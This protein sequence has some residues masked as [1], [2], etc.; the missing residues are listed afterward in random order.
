MNS[1]V[2]HASSS[3]DPLREFTNEKFAKVMAGFTPDNKFERMLVQG[4]LFRYLPK[5][6]YSLGQGTHVAYDFDSSYVAGLN[7]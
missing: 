4:V 2:E 3:D 5:K 1:E 6:N 7:Q